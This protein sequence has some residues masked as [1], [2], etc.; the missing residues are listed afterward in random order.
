MRQQFTL[1][2]SIALLSTNLSVF[3]QEYRAAF[4]NFDALVNKENT[5]LFYGKEYV[6]QHATI[7][8]QHKFF[9]APG[10]LKGEVVY[11]G[12][13]YFDLDLKYNVFDD[14][15]IVKI[16]KQSGDATFELFKNR[17]E[18]FSIDGHTFVNIPPGEETEIQ[19]FFEV[20]RETSPL[21]LLKDH[22]KDI[23]KILTRTFTYFEFEPD[24]PHY[25]IAISEEYFQ[26]NSQSD[27]IRIFPE[28]SEVI[29]KYFNSKEA[30]RESDPDSFMSGLFLEISESY[31]SNNS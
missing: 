3:S 11:S 6:E 4:N 10:F 5:N 24:L 29:R 23:N 1:L 28:Y 26:A 25:A 9:K 19:G 13:T 17:I 12:Q 27:W 22:R 8:N 31:K 18:S 21:K 2:I 20:I 16:N 30:L 15:L 7:N 14:L